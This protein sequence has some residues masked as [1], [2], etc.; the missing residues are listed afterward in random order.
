MDE[1]LEKKAEE[2]KARIVSMCSKYNIPKNDLQ[3]LLND[4]M[5]Y[6][7]DLQKFYEEREKENK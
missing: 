7:L 4:Y 2:L 6:H 1:K 5:L 3:W